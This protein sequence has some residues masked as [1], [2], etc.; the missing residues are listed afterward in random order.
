MSFSEW[1]IDPTGGQTMLYL[2][3]T[4]ISSVDLAHYRIFRAKNWVSKDC[5]TMM[6]VC[7]Y[8]SGN[9]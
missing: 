5:G 9:H 7:L 3:C 1:I 4:I 6:I 8:L 2:S